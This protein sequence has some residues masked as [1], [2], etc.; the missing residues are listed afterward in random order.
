MDE[1]IIAI[2]LG[3]LIVFV[4][5]AGLT[6]RFALKPLIDS[7]L[8]LAEARRATPDVQLLERR[9]AAVEQE[10]RGLKGEIREVAGPK[11]DYGRLPG[12]Q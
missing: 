9:L 4:P 5:I 7:L 3:G 6:L 10:L 2:L 1:G 11:E 12:P 8:K